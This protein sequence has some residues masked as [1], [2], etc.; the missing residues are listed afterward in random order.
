MKTDNFKKNDYETRCGLHQGMLRFVADNIG[1]GLDLDLDYI[2]KIIK[3]HL[4]KWESDGKY[5][6]T[7]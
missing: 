7:A 5:S 4:E 6:K 2:K 3:D 1:E